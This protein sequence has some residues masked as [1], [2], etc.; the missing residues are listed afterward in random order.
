MPVLHVVFKK[1]D[2][3]SPYKM[4][5]YVAEEITWKDPETTWK[6]EESSQIQFTSYPSKDTRQVNKTVL[7]SLDWLS[8]S[9][10]SLSNTM[11]S[12]RITQLSLSQI[13]E[14]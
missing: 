2:S 5:S 13:P 7:A 10:K 6:G 14:P 12:R 8:M 3:I 1:S 11:W 4:P 9:W